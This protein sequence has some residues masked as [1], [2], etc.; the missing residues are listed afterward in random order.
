MSLNNPCITIGTKGIISYDEN[1]DEI[2]TPKINASTLGN[3]LKAAILDLIYPVGS[4]YTTTDKNINPGTIFGGTWISIKDVFLYGADPANPPT[5]EHLTG[6]SKKIT[7]DNLPEHTHTGTSSTTVTTGDNNNQFKLR[8]GKF[9]T[10]NGATQDDPPGVWDIAP[11]LWYLWG[12]QNTQGGSTY[13]YGCDSYPGQ[14][15]NG[16]AHTHSVTISKTGSGTD[17]LPPYRVVYV[18]ERTG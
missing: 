10:L 16:M 9:I 6:G 15:W 18:Y 8:N 7:I 12:G 17:F 13:E 1:N 14:A 2:I 11:G 3:D 4:I 5:A